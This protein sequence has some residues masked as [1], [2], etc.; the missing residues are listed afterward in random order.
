MSTTPGR[1]AAPPLLDVLRRNPGFR[2]VWSAQ[3]VSMA[4]DWLNRMA[5]LV[6]IGELGG[7]GAQL[8]VGV[9]YGVEIVVRLLPTALLGPLAGPI[10]DR[11]PRRRIMVLA[12]LIRAALV[13]GFLW[14]D[15]PGELPW[16][17]GLLAAQMGT[18]IFFESARSA[19]LPNL[20]ARDELYAAHAISAATWSTMLA[21]GAALG[22]FVTEAFGTDVV[23]L[24][25]AGTYVLSALLLIGLRLP[26]PPK[27]EQVFRW[28]D[29]IT[30]GDMRRGL[31]HVRMLGLL[32]AVFAKSF[33]CPAGGYLALLAIAGDLRFGTAVGA[34]AA[35][36]TLYA[37]RGV[38]T[39][40]GPILARR[41]FG[42]EDAALRVQIGLGFVL[43][44]V[45]YGLFGLA[46]TLWAAG[47]CV[48]IA[49]MGGSSIWVASSALYQRHVDDAF[50][51]RVHALDFL[52]MT[53]SFALAAIAAGWL[54]DATDS[55][56]ITAGVLSALLLLSVG[57][58]WRWSR[59]MLNGA[60]REARG[61]GEDG[62]AS[63]S[64]G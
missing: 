2:R 25:D 39:G 6:L 31:T 4:G 42:S 7:V 61:V 41:V 32:P 51:G 46:E 28:A 16:L 55:I 5:V 21:L 40:V 54:H 36:S 22:G 24:A 38:G 43:A 9:L 52:A 29:F 63:G 56:A 8:G 19:S 34:A 26:P 59:G 1:P 48:L 44:A 13:L 23:F 33:W 49:H 60:V 35:T 53:F 64:A 45:L 37:L 11:F 18:S 47:A 12:D 58:W 17:Y 10:A 57:V 50:R 27:Q 14:I 30:F 62:D 3:V 20:V 15:E